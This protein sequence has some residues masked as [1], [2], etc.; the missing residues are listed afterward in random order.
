MEIDPPRELVQTWKPEWEG[1]HETKLTFVL[2]PIE[3]GTRV[4]LRHEGFGARADSCRSHGS[5]WERVFEWLS[6]YV[7]P[8]AAEAGKYFLCRLLPPRASFAFDMTPAERTVMQEHVM[9]YSPFGPVRTCIRH[10]TI[11]RAHL[12]SSHVSWADEQ[13]V[14]RGLGAGVRLAFGL[15]CACD[16]YDAGLTHATSLETSRHSVDDDAGQDASGE[17]AGAE[18]CA[19]NRDPDAKC[20]ARC[21]EL[22]NGRDD[23]CDGVVDE[24]AA[25]LRCAGAYADAVCRAGSC[26]IVQ[27]LADHRDCDQHADNGCEIERDDPRHCGTCGH[28]CAIDHADSVCVSGRCRVV[29]CLDGYADC[30]GDRGSCETRLDTLKNCGGCD[31][32]C[33]ELPHALSRC[34]NGECKFDKCVE[35][36]ADCDRD[37]KNGCEAAL[38]T[39]QNCGECGKPCPL[40]NCAGG[41]CSPVNC[42]EEVGSADC[43]RDQVSCE[44]NLRTDVTH[45]GTC[46]NRCRFLVL[47]PHG[48]LTCNAGR[49]GVRC[50]PGYADC[51]G[52]YE[53]GCETALTTVN[54]CGACGRSC[55]IADATESCAGGSCEVLTCANGFGDCDRD[56]KSC[57]TALNTPNTCGTCQSKCSLP[58]ATPR[59]AIN[60]STASCAIAG[61]EA[62][63]GDCDGLPANGCERDLREPGRGGQGPCMPDVGCTKYVSGDQQFYVCS[64]ERTWSD[65]RARC[66]S[67]LR[68][69]LAHV[70]NPATRDF[71]K[72]KLPIRAWVGHSDEAIEGLWILSYNQV[73]FWSGAATGRALNGDFNNWAAGEPNDSGDCGSMY[74]T[75]ELDDFT[76]STPN[77]YVCQVSPD[78]CPNSAS[79]YDPGQCGCGKADTDSN[80]DG[81]ADC[82]TGG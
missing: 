47:A 67:Q 68:G 75:G 62:E 29:S 10:S 40:A 46:T 76:C 50:A 30:D 69:D 51:D 2:E 45:C 65:A 60:G 8:S 20:R 61:C 55:T 24:A 43:D 1:G 44:V 26:V 7:A 36:F 18:G 27:C 6:A 28:E 11:A 66:R 35:G 15:L 82:T 71:L 73:P 23:D 13:R 19:T 9:P 37:L 39:L 25:D 3:A 42:D 72:G 49:C 48:E 41:E 80:G 33:P 54:D 21:N 52:F 59:C 53:D 4:V 57:E 5:G 81:F 17:D 14:M 64:T 34:S 79:K 38:D 74:N 77:P 63:W 32:E 31:H 70:S 56:R 16:V 22:C 78:L 12:G 58:H